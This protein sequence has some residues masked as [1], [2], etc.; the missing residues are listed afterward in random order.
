MD[1]KKI[2]KRTENWKAKKDEQNSKKF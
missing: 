2:E 1:S